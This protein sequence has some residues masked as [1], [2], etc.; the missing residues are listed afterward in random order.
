[1]T[2]TAAW[3]PLRPHEEQSEMFRC[4]KRVVHC[5]A[6][7]ISGKTTIARRRMCVALPEKKP[8]PDR[9]YFYGLPTYGQ[10]KRVAWDKILSL[11]PKHWLK[12]EPSSSSMLIE[13]VFGS[14]LYV[15]GLDKPARIEGTEWDGCII[16]ESSDQK[17][18][19]FERSIAPAL[20]AREGWCWRIGAPKRFGPGGGEFRKA[21]ERGLTGEGD[22]ASFTWPSWTVLSEKE[23]EKLRKEMS[24]KDFDEQIAG[25]FQ[26]AGGS[27]YYAW[28]KE[29]VKDCAYNPNELMLVMSDF[30][31][32][33]M[34]WCMGH[35]VHTPHGQG[36][37]VFDELWLRNTNTQ[38]ALDEVWKRYEH[39]KGGFLFVGDATGRNRHTSANKSDYRQILNDERFGARVRYDK[40]NPAIKDRLASVNSLLCNKLGQ[41]R[42][43]MDPKCVHLIDD[44]KYRSLD[45][46]GL[47]IASGPNAAGDSGHMSDALGYGVYKFF[48]ITIAINSGSELIIIG[49]GHD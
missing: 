30:N 31:V 45:E 34:A 43:F 41:R 7:R 2:L 23:I 11:I 39:H 9:N 5:I 48:P 33:P 12:K 47:P 4:D 29:N 28:S 6:G 16:D 49:E 32:D 26:D 22:S 13:T 37:E 35:F 20:A 10:A 24:P 38:A 27:A 46:N 25:E 14:R 40:H 18:G 42:L 21:Y 8:W 15:L 44:M 1:M 3:T 17:P 19:V 36:M